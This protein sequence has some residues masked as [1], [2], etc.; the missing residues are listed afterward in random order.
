MNQLQRPTSNASPVFQRPA[1]QKRDPP[2]REHRELLKY[3]Q[4]WGIWT[5][6]PREQIALVPSISGKILD[7]NAGERGSGMVYEI[8]VV[9]GE[10]YAVKPDGGMSRLAQRR[11]DEIRRQIRM[12]EVNKAV[13]EL[14]TKQHSVVY[15]TYAVD[16]KQKPRSM[17][18]VAAIM[19]IHFSTVDEHLKAAY[20]NLIPK[21]FP[22]PVF[23]FV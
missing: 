8:V 4:D 3:L 7:G 19:N 15:L 2:S 11:A 12:R 14:T 13:R 17:R 18:D 5:K 23:Q 20:K 21:V 16:R 22:Q 10:S 1:R 9:D 6:E